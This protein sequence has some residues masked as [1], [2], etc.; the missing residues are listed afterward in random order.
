MP[1]LA[2]VLAVVVGLIS[3][4][5]SAQAQQARPAYLDQPA[6]LRM[7]G[8]PGHQRVPLIVVLPA[9]G[10]EAARVY[11]WLR[12]ALPLRS[13]ALLLPAG[14]P[15]TAEYLPAFGKYVD[16]YQERLLA[17]IDRAVQTLPIHR[18]CIYL[19]GFSLGGDLSCAMLARHSARFRGAYVIGSRCS[20]HF[21]SDA[22]A[23][24]KQHNARV[25]FSIGNVDDA[26]RIAGIT[27]AHQRIEQA[28]IPTRLTTYDAAHEIAPTPVAREAFTFLFTWR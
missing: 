19:V 4:A 12:S 21:K 7:V 17:D 1:W 3:V 8:N 15:T 5:A 13:Y 11:E 6:Q 2:R 20:S 24:L 9:T 23:T 10:V 16:W 22:L 25:V 27:R 14:T 26:K 18:E 28:Q